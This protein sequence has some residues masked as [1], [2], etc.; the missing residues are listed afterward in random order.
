[1]LLVT[2]LLISLTLGSSL[3]DG[4][5]QYDI[6]ALP[7]DIIEESLAHRLC[8]SS[9]FRLG[10]TS[11]RFLGPLGLCFIYRNTYRICLNNQFDR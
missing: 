11:K 2:V 4:N 1:M 9:L 10:L 6:N 8:P 5:Q 3:K 7:T